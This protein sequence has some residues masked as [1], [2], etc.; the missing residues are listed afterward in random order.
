MGTEVAVLN[1]KPQAPVIFNPEQV[2]L[3]R[4]T[5]AKDCGDDELKL[6]LYQC[7]RT[8]LDPFARQIY[9]IKRGGKMN[10]Q[11]SIDGYR[12]TAERSGKYEGQ[13]PVWWCGADGVWVDV[14]LQGGNPIA[15]KVGVYRA[16]F[17]EALWAVAKW[18]EYADSNGPMWRKMGALMLGKCAEAL[19]LRKAFPQEL[20]GLYTAEEMD[21]ANR[22][23]AAQET[24][25]EVVQAL[26]DAPPA[27]AVSDEEIKAWRKWRAAANKSLQAAKSLEDLESKRTGLEEVTKQGP[28]LWLKRTYHNDFETFGS[29]FAEHKMRVERDVA[30]AG[31]EGIK[32]WIAGVMATPS[33]RGLEGFVKQYRDE[34][35]FQIPECEA[36]LHERALQLGLSSFTDVEADEDDEDR[37]KD[38]N[39]YGK[40]G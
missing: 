7:Q 13:T 3:I 26:P 2:D 34:M 16:G 11:T 18:A 37:I 30:M 5:I 10:I 28:E 32:V 12:L 25:A 39:P 15:A 21:Q 6:F 38:S 35:R 36:A 17:R 29:L 9:A 33:P 27:P 19:A 24:A 20:S 8:G 22:P 1:G 40:M 4:R 23:D 14:W 31:P